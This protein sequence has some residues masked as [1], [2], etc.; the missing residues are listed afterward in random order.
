MTDRGIAALEADDIVRLADR[1]KPGHESVEELAALLD[2]IERWDREQIEAQL[3]PGDP[4]RRTRLAGFTFTPAEVPL[5]HLR[6]YPG[7]GGLPRAWTDGGSVADTAHIVAARGVPNSAL[8][9]D[10]MWEWAR[11]HR[12][13]APHWL[14]SLPLIALPE[15]HARAPLPAMPLTLEDG[16]HRAVVLAMLGIAS[17]LCWVGTVR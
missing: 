3:R 13:Q 14:T 4:V 11:T 6:P 1:L 8:R 10:R 9:L 12:A 5:S 15:Y 17:A 16:S 2:D 7:M